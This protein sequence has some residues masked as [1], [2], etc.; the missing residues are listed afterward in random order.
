MTGVFLPAS[1][2][3][4]CSNISW[5]TFQQSI[6]APIVPYFPFIASIPAAVVQKPVITVTCRD[7][8]LIDPM[9]CII[10]LHILHDFFGTSTWCE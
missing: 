6:C 9:L 2:E 5:L 1:Y 4:I 7:Q 3:D 10:I 8:S